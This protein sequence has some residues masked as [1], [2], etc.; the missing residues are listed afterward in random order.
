MANSGGAYSRKTADKAARSP[1][2]YARQ[3][4]LSSTSRVI[5]PNSLLDLYGRRIAGSGFFSFAIH[6]FFGAPHLS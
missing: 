5:E 6:E 2:L 4:S 3:S 1:R